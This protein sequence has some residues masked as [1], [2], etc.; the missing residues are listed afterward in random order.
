MATE[1]VIEAAAERFPI[2]EQNRGQITFTVTNQGQTPD[3]A[4]LEP[5]P[6]DGTD[7][8]WFAVEEPQRLV[9]GGGSTPYL[10]TATIPAG[11]P[12]GTYWVQGRVY[13]ADTAPEESSRLSDRVVFE[14]TQSAPA[15]KRQ[16]WPYAVA[17]ALAVVVLAVVGVLV[18]N[19]DDPSDVGGEPTASSTS[20]TSPAPSGPDVANRT[21]TSVRS[22]VVGPGQSADVVA[23][24]PAGTF[25]VGGGYFRRSITGIA[26]DLSRPLSSGQGW[27]VH[28]FNP[29]NVNFDFDGVAVCASVRDHQVVTGPAVTLPPGQDAN[30]VASCPAGRVSTGGGGSALGVV[31]DTTRPT[32]DGQ[33]WQIHA[34]N[35]TGA[36]ITI[37]AQAVC[38]TAPSRTAD[39]R[40]F[41]VQPGTRNEVVVDCPAGTV[42]TGG[43]HSTPTGLGLDV[44]LSDPSNSSGWDVRADNRT[45]AVHE[46]TAHVVCASSG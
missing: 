12:A 42:A 22:P 15:K 6:G 5:V 39:T 37:S 2:N 21:V 7:R 38:A 19:R 46:V 13:S 35:N 34:L 33:G 24:C 28:G 1:W 40:S 27:Q 32:A 8:S 43:G 14:V 23:S 4:V 10:M 17:A 31:I 20:S 18:F 41:T 30:A 36:A 11:T 16:W 3:R 26:V 29:T 9:T 45:G 25:V 44:F